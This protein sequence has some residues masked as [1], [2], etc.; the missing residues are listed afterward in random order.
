MCNRVWK[1]TACALA[2]AIAMAGTS[3]TAFAMPGEGPLAWI[4]VP[5]Q[6]VS[7]AAQVSTN[8]ELNTNTTD[9]QPDTQ[10]ENLEGTMAAAQVEEY[11]HIR[12]LPSEEGEVLG[13]LYSGC[14]A[15]I[16]GQEGDWIQITSGSVTGYINR[17]Y[18][19]YGQD[20]QPVIDAAKTKQ[21]T[22]NTETLYVRT[23]MSTEAPIL[24]GLAQG[25]TVNVEE[26]LDGWERVRLGEQTGYIKTDY[27]SL[28]EIFPTAES[29]E[30]EAARLA[31]EEEASH[32]ALRDEITSFAC[33][34]VGNPYVWGGTSLTNGA[35][36]SGFVKSVYEHFGYSLPR[37]SRA[38]AAEASGISEE[39]MQPGD[40]I[41][42]ARGGSVNHVAM[43]IGEGQVVHAS[44]P[45]TGIKISRYDYR[46]PVKIVSYL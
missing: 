3:V 21:A 41:F 32:Q 45:K 8:E 17:E 35:D 6:N 13:K 37:T 5:L 19:I 23:D 4:S 22:V 20:A 29:N 16:L 34:F 36:C 38:Q 31:A 44:S 27:V 33:Q 15:T 28:E 46:S 9:I 1:V 40:L 12:S 42:Y 7:T 11:V 26:S 14:V 25:E 10:P 2:G 30:E 39:E 24:D 43:Y 18:L